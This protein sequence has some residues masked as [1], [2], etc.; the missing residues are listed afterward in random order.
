MIE[1]PAVTKNA[2]GTK[3]RC[4]SCELPFYDLARTPIVCPNCSETF[5][6][7]VAATPR[8]SEPKPISNGRRAPWS[9]KKASA[10]PVADEPL[11][12]ADA[13]ADDIE[14]VE[15]DDE[16]EADD[17]TLLDPDA[18]TDDDEVVVATKDDSD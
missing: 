5:V 4:L 3:H 17:D 14:D 11:A 18:E 7:V 16:I 13:D 2:R 10:E 12:T 1:L 9:Q 6:P 8:L 15:D